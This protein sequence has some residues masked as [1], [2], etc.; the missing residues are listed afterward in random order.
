MGATRV[1]CAVAIVLAAFLATLKLDR[2]VYASSWSG[3][4][5]TTTTTTTKEK[6]ATNTTYNSSWS[7]MTTTSN[8]SSPTLIMH[9]GPRKTATTSIQMVLSHFKRKTTYLSQD[10]FVYLN[11]ER[12]NIRRDEKKF[13][14]RFEQ[15]RLSGTN[16]IYSN[17]NLSYEIATEEDFYM[18]K[19]ALPGWDIRVVA[20]YRRYFDWYLSEYQQEVDQ[21]LV[22]G[23]K[24]RNLLRYYE[25]T[26]I[27]T[28]FSPL[29]LSFINRWRR[30]FKKFHIFNMHDSQNSNATNEIYERFVCEVIPEAKH[31]CQAI[32]NGQLPPQRKHNIHYAKASTSAKLVTQALHKKNLLHFN[33][34]EII[35]CNDQVDKYVASRYNGTIDDEKLLTC[36][37]NEGV[38]NILKTSI[39]NERDLVPEFHESENGLSRLTSLFFAAVREKRFC[40]LNV[41]EF[42]KREQ[43]D[44]LQVLLP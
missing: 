30:H 20:T 10:S 26:K 11:R 35:L 19:N 12:I 37:P 40:Q 18:L 6:E 5:T 38:E 44:L 15:L 4:T 41:D 27:N 22:R 23:F 3:M 29:D 39:I 8:A 17:E 7:D 14:G 43:D 1:S 25:T 24:A 36:I 42:L 28:I 34:T 13:R 21:G 16:V 2:D 9:L 32:K 31:T 33:K